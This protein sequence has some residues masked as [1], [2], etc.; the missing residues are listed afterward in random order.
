MLMEPPTSPRNLSAKQRLIVALDLKSAN[1]AWEMVETLGEEVEFYKVGWRLFLAAGLDFVTKLRESGKHVFLDLKMDDIGETIQT[2]LELI[3]GKADLL[4]L[5]GGSSTIKAAAAGRGNDQFPKLLSVTFLSSMNA[6]DLGD[7]YGIT[8]SAAEFDFDAFILHR[9]QMAID[10][11]ADGWI[12]SGES[13]GLLRQR[14]GSEPLIV[15]PGIRPSGT[16]TNEHKR[17]LTPAEA[18]QLG[19]DHLVVGRPI[20]AAS[21]PKAAACRILEEIASTEQDRTG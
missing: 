20:R 19:A 4:T 5:Q 12:A 17:S 2:A 3:S 9:A 1:E 16:P 14:F 18:I 15:C 21:D 11:G 10:A 7:V 6:Q 8:G 13:V